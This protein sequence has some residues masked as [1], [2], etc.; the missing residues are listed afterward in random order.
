[1]Q[2]LEV[3]REYLELKVASEVDP[4]VVEIEFDR[5]SLSPE[6]KQQVPAPSLHPRM[7]TTF[8]SPKG[9]SPVRHSD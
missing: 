6:A 2:Q 7:K 3:A 5:G 9:K 4:D 8:Q 1:M